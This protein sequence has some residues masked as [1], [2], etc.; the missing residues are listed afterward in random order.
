[1]TD[2]KRWSQDPAERPWFDHTDAAQRLEGRR[3]AE[4]LS[5]RDLEVLTQWMESGYAVV[6]NV[7]PDADIDGM[8]GDLDALW[9]ASTP[10]DNLTIADLR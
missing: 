5:E 4:Q 6:K 9:T 7:V 2:M 8:L 10:I 1:M 3:H